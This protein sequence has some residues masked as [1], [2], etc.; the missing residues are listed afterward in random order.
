[1]VFFYC[2][3]GQDDSKPSKT[4]QDQARPS[5]TMTDSQPEDTTTRAIVKQ[6]QSHFDTFD[7]LGHE[8]KQ[9]HDDTR[10]LWKYTKELHT[11]LQSIVQLPTRYADLM[12]EEERLRIQTEHQELMQSVHKM[13]GEIDTLSTS[14]T[15]AKT[16]K[17]T[18]TVA[19]A[20][21]KADG[22]E[23]AEKAEEAEK[24]QSSTTNLTD[25][26]TADTIAQTSVTPTNSPTTTPI[27][28]APSSTY[29]N[30][31]TPGA[32]PLSATLDVSSVDN[33]DDMLMSND[34]STGSMTD[35]YT[36][37]GTSASSSS[38][39]SSSSSPSS[40]SSS[41]SPSSPTSPTS[42][43]SPSSS[44]SVPPT[45]VTQPKQ[46]SRVQKVQQQHTPQHASYKPNDAPHKN[47]HY[48]LMSLPK[49][50]TSAS[51]QQRKQKL[52]LVRQSGNG[53]VAPVSLQR[54]VFINTAPNRQDRRYRLNKIRQTVPQVQ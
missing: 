5:K 38:L 49:H 40:L 16:T 54:H 34:S 30:I 13:Q 18:K 6:L 52:N 8:H 31:V 22:A 2:L 24:P 10:S 11:T 53:R 21:K 46:Q 20:Q 27:T 26:T 3:Q 23:K 14:A 15:P 33:A 1:M 37:L 41:T 19:V 42:P 36:V 39:S 4:K 35:D 17:T 48:T 45:L 51:E 44:S 7:A 43:S 50:S 25:R 12:N 47:G 28:T 29:S 32:P 9:S